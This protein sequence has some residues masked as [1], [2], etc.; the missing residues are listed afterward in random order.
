MCVA[1]KIQSAIVLCCF[2][3][4][5]GCAG[6]NSHTMG[7]AI[8]NS[9]V[10]PVSTLKTV[11]TPVTVKGVMFEKCPVAG[12]WFKIRDKSGE[13]KVD[14]KAAGFVVSDVPLQTEVT[15]Q[16]KFINGDERRI[17]AT[18]ITY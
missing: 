17:A 5:A 2:A 11:A 14:T 10:M 16:G 13:I 12:C 6:S 18:G 9:T 15:V 4:L 3:A 8:T 7:A 1:R